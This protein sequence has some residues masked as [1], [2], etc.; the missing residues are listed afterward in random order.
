MSIATATEK[1]AVDSAIVPNAGQPQYWLNPPKIK[2]DLIELKT[3]LFNGLL[4]AFIA[5]GFI[6]LYNGLNL[7]S[8]PESTGIFS[9][10]AY[11]TIVV[12]A[13]ESLVIGT[14]LLL[15]TRYF[16]RKAELQNSNAKN[17]VER[18]LWD[19]DWFYRS[20]EAVLKKQSARIAGGLCEHEAADIMAGKSVELRTYSVNPKTAYN[21][22][23]TSVKLKLGEDNPK[24]IIKQNLRVTEHPMLPYNS[25]THNSQRQSNLQVWPN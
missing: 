18:Y 15:I 19:I 17:G 5:F 6:L 12:G 11:F 16:V 25:Y 14:L 23:Q 10:F 2:Y 24:I 1:P 9:F 13:I 20:C 21:P 22:G 7:Q 3:G 8:L 4:F